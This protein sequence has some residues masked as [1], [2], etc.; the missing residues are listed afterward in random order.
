MLL[1]FQIIRDKPF[2]TFF[3]NLEEF[4]FTRKQ[5]RL[6]YYYEKMNA[7]SVPTFTKHLNM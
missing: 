2:G 3:H 7:E 4:L 1:C 6:D 5:T